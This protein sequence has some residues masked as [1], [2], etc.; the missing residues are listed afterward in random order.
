MNRLRVAGF[1][2]SGRDVGAGRIVG[3]RMV[4]LI[5]VGKVEGGEEEMR[6]V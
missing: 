1:F 4:G 3:N 6:K 2:V 5:I